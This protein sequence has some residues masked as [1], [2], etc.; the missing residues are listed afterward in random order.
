MRRWMVLSILL[1]GSV[2]HA[3][4][5]VGKPSVWELMKY[6]LFVHFVFGGEYGG[7]TPIGREG[8][9]PPDIDAFAEAFD[10]EAFASNVQSMGFE[11]VIFTAWHAN[12]G[13]LYPSKVMAD[14][15]FDQKDHYTKRRDL[16]GEVID[17]LAQR[18]IETSLYTH[19]FV[20]HDFHPAGTGYFSYDN[21][22]GV[23]TS[24][25][26]N[27][28]YVDAVNG[29]STKWND[30]L[31]KVYDEMSSRY[32]E[33]VSSYWFDGTWVPNSWVDKERLMGTIRKTNRTCA[34][35][36]N[37]D[38]AG[39][40]MPYGAKEVGWG[41]PEDKSLGFVSDFP[42]VS[43]LDMTTWPSYTR[44]IA[45]IQG[46]NW[47]ATRGGRRRYS[48]ETIYR[49]S[50]LQAATSTSG[51]MSWAFSPYVDGSWEADNLAE[52]RRAYS[53]LRPI[54]EAVKKTL[55]STSF[56]SPEGTK[57]GTLTRR[58][59]ATRSADD[60]V[61]YIHVLKPPSG[62][63]LE[64][65]RPVDGKVFHLAELL[66]GRIPATL[67][68]TRS[69]YQIELPAG[70]S[71]DS[72]NTVFRLRHRPEPSTDIARDRPVT[73]SS[74]CLG[75]V[76]RNVV[77]STAAAGGLWS[78][79]LSGEGG[80]TGGSV[81]QWL[82]VDL[83][84]SHRRWSLKSWKVVST[85]DGSGA[86]AAMEL[87]ASRDGTTWTPIDSVADNRSKVME[88]P[89]PRLEAPRYARVRITKASSNWDPRIK[90]SRL[91]LGAVRTARL[92]AD[93]DWKGASIGL[94]EGRYA[95]QDLV[96][97]GLPDNSL[98]SLAVP[99]GWR[100]ELYDEDGYAKPLGS[101]TADVASLVASGWN[102][103]ATSVVVTSTGTV[104]IRPKPFS[105]LRVDGRT[106]RIAGVSEG[107]LLERDLSGRILAIHPIREGRARLSE[108]P[109]GVRLLEVRTSSLLDP[110]VLRAVVP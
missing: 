84:D 35:V 99:E 79:C 105:K 53:F 60:S 89:L 101:A 69:G 16:L 76:P 10:A 6:G 34:F 12:M 93:T 15:G 46:G 74:A 85:N 104:G 47:W 70:R 18:G 94:G 65:P 33:K 59:V 67:R 43:N 50:V 77:S 25:M 62:T 55:P 80:Y 36:A 41:G 83:G 88:R 102:D 51:G 40:G 26:V 39:H 97:L 20:G 23:V 19:I 48:A 100:V 64:L 110:S 14:H 30:F 3:R 21:R 38:A 103:R 49:Y 73:S 106:V 56:P 90:M 7:M 44:S 78:S 61:E 42:P 13:V 1:T 8:G 32:G 2:T 63:T 58:F 91:E 92:Y 52:M 95:S 72:L 108:G 82:T 17:A 28:G 9:F 66:P 54:E 81:P 5:A 75:N 98:S 27:S 109:K 37:G 107:E 71:W 4:T 31:N 29:N 96:A 68:P 57:I 86:I 87:Q 11:Y 22:Q 45:M 24:D